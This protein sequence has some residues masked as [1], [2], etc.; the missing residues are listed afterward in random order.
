MIVR[1]ILVVDDSPTDR[2]IISSILIQNG[3]Q[4]GVAE[5]GE[6]GVAKI[7]EINPDLVLMDVVMPGM[8]GY[9]ATRIII[10]DSATCHI[11]IILC[12][13]KNQPTDKIWGLRQGAQDYITKPVIAEEL[14]QK[15]TALN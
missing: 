9:Q 11:P 8:N 13:T 3:Y 10:R 6:E 15:I 14:L 5:N 2:H 4:V 7:K 1:K 12:T